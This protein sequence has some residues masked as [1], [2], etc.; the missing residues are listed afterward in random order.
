MRDRTR[1]FPAHP[2]ASPDGLPPPKTVALVDGVLESAL[3]YQY[4]HWQSSSPASIEELLE[5]FP[6]LRLADGAIID[7]IYGEYF[8]RKELGH[9]VEMQDYGRQFPQYAAT[10]EQQS[11]LHAAL[12][13]LNPRTASAPLSDANFQVD[14]YSVI[15]E[16]GRGGMG[17][18]FKAH[19]HTLRRDVAIKAI[20][21]E[22]AHREKWRERFAAEAAAIARM[23][24][25]NFVQI[26]DFGLAGGHPYLVLELVAG[27][28]LADKISGV[29]QP[30]VWA[31]EVIETL[32]L[33]IHHAHEQH[34]VHRDL[35][36]ANVLLSEHGVLKITDLGL[37][38]ELPESVA[39]PAAKERPTPSIAELYGTPPY[40]APEQLNGSEQEVGPATDIYALGVILYE[41]L[42]GRVPFFGGN[43]L[44][45]LAQIREQAVIPPRRLR[46][47]IPRDLET[48]CLKCLEK[49]PGNRYPHAAALAEDIR[50]FRM[51]VPITARPVGAVEHVWRWC[52]R[53]P[54][55]ATLLV[56]LLASVTLGLTSM[57]VM[58]RESER[59]RKEAHRNLADSQ[60]NLQLAIGAVDQFC[61]HVAEDP[62]MK[63]HDL[64]NL[65]RQ[66][67]STAVDFHRQLLQKQ[68]NEKGGT[69]HLVEAYLRLGHL[70][71]E[72]DT[73][74]RALT[75]FQQ[76]EYFAR[77]LRHE[78]RTGVRDR[79]RVARCL[80]E[81]SRIRA[82]MGDSGQAEA[83]LLEA[84]D[85]AEAAASHFNDEQSLD[86]DTLRGGDDA[87]Q[88]PHFAM[89][90]ALSDLG[91]LIKAGNRAE[92]AERYFQHA[93]GVGKYLLANY[94]D[95]PQVVRE[96]AT[97]HNRLGDLYQTQMIGKRRLSEHTY[98]RSMELLNSLAKK[99]PL[100]ASLRAKIVAIQRDLARLL[101]V[102]NRREEAEQE[103][104]RAIETQKSLV[105]E[106]GSVIEF[107]RLL[108][109]LH[110]DLAETIGI[111]TKSAEA[112]TAVRQALAIGERLVGWDPGDNRLLAEL[113]HFQEQMAF[114][115][116]SRRH[117]D[118]A[119]GRWNAAIETLTVASE[120][121]PE[122]TFARDR[123]GSAYAERASLRTE[124]GDF[125]GAL[126][127]W[128]QAL[129]RQPSILLPYYQLQRAATLCAT[130][131]HVT[132]TQQAQAILN[133]LPLNSGRKHSFSAAAKVFG[134][135]MAI[136]QLD[137]RLSTEQQRSF[138]RDY[139]EC[140]LHA[141][142]QARTEGFD[143]PESLGIP[144]L[145]PLL[146]DPGFEPIVRAMQ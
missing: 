105:A 93:I 125:D 43:L 81:V 71:T 99:E 55:M 102:D 4:A 96:L 116:Q 113:G 1:V 133:R 30:P 24:H 97:A 144:E 68:R 60:Q 48:I 131:D 76:A 137:P 109:L 119:I 127:D 62:R 18:V 90:L 86:N 115:E 10:L 106:H 126:Q 67:L 145:W 32:A 2:T 13:G 33:A 51:G 94:P 29:A 138:E 98:T 139:R 50:R 45:T 79:V 41:T 134:R 143:E 44:E 23:R 59:L 69:A 47:E 36:P 5:R 8:V 12:V 135:A 83:D 54:G 61:T 91:Y 104:R 103:L 9:A 114:L 129:T 56:L 52:H 58:W 20:L 66:L 118:Q 49:D 95:H 35:K 38:V 22:H 124:Q 42:T 89:A 112:A 64:W 92:E 84:Y 111:R 73:T 21:A 28:T 25:P 88:D 130:G 142:E 11:E 14:G 121:D 3:E 7:L 132:A 39:L 65:R 37:A 80:I 72:I 87:L 120:R 74:S 141:L 34:L 63:Q 110:S 108:A 100:N 70:S 15:A 40:M 17:V 85:L 31:S 146:G 46:P 123:L 57:T 27:G 117:A 6:I 122:A 78:H 107:Q 26:Y 16:L 53:N 101:R 75:Y 77:D 128:D 140:A 136:S 19:Q 82:E